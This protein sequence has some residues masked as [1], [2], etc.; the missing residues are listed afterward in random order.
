MPVWPVEISMESFRRSH[1]LEGESFWHNVFDMHKDKMQIKNPNVAIKNLEKIFTA[2][3]K[4]TTEK[5]FQAMSLRDLSRE[6]GISM[7]GLYSYIGSKNDLASVIEGVLRSTIEQVIGG[8]STQNLQLIKSLQAIVYAEIYMMEIMR[9]WY[10]FCFMELKGLPRDQQK[11]ALDLELRFEVILMGVFSAGIESGQF[12]CKKPELL[13][14]QITAQLQQWHLK[15][16]KF[17]L[18]NVDAQEY[19]QSIFENLLMCLACKAEVISDQRQGDAVAS[20]VEN[21]TRNENIA[22]IDQPAY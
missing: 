4:L 10:Y 15:Q 20:S 1:N 7:G 14:S 22:E 12:V 19:A 3:F 6:T 11:Q 18:R 2:T 13:A 5:G 17:K 8:L 9:P 16:W 21:V